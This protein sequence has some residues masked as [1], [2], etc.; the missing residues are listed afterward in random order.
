MDMLG[1]HVVVTT[2]HRGVFGGELAEERHGYKVVVLKT[3]RMCVYWP[4]E[5][6]GVFGL[7]ANGPPAKS[8][9]SPAVPMQTIYDVTAVALST[10]GAIKAWDAEPWS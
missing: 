1:K 6:K 2:A 8:R 9:V 7:A 10:E 4:A 3:C 5:T